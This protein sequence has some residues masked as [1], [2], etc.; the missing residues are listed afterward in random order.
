MTSAPETSTDPGHGTL[1]GEIERRLDAAGH[2]YTTGRRALVGALIAAGRP[3]G[4]PEILEASPGLPQSSVYRNLTVLEQATVVERHLVNADHARYELAESLVGHH[5]HLLCV[6]CGAIDD[7]HVSPELERA[8]TAMLEATVREQ[9][10]LMLGHR[11][12]LTGVCHR[13]A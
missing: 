12:H 6:R 8:L 10:F 2:R 13:C 11:L 1:H 4:L 5:H 3:L 7:A 9:H